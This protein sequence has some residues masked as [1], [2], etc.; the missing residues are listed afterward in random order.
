M[1]EYKKIQKR[2]EYLYIY[3]SDKGYNKT[4]DMHTDCDI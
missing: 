1:R 3:K 2:R 4:H